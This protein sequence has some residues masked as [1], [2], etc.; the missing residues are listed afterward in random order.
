M[1]DPERLSHHRRV[2]LFLVAYRWASLLPALWL[3]RS[4]ERSLAM[5]IA[6]GLVLAI[7]AGVTLLITVFPPRPQPPVD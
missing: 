1:T 6:P 7:A 3:L 2:F 5:S 4:G